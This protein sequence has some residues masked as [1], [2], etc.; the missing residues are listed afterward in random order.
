MD[1]LNKQQKLTSTISSI[2]TTATKTEQG[3]FFKLEAET[4]L[5][6]KQSQNLRYGLE[7]RDVFAKMIAV[8]GMWLQKITTSEPDESQLEVAIVALNVAL[9][10]EVT[11]ATEVFE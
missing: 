2:D 10:N 8:P 1:D 5:S 4:K 9:G 6:D 7:G 3:N 11:N